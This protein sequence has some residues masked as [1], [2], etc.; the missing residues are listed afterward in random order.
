[1]H[2]PSRAEQKIVQKEQEE[3]IT[4]CSDNPEGLS[5][6]NIPVYPAA[7]DVEMDPIEADVDVEEGSCRRRHRCVNSEK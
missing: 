7:P 6:L 4:V 1:M 2:L 5:P 3:R